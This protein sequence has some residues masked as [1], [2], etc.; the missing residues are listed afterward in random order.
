MKNSLAM[1][2]PSDTYYCNL[3]IEENRPV[4]HVHP[5]EDIEKMEFSFHE[6]LAQLLQYLDSN[7]LLPLVENVDAIDVNSKEFQERMISLQNHWIKQKYILRTCF[8]GYAFHRFE[9]FD[10]DRQSLDYLQNIGI[11]RL[12]KTINTVNPVVSQHKLMDIIGEIESKLNDLYHSRRLTQEQY[13]QMRIHRSKVELNHLLFI[14]DKV[15]LIVHIE[16]SS[17]SF[18]FFL[19]IST[20]R[21]LYFH[22]HK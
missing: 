21:S 11:Y 19:V 7:E 13:D 3:N 18:L 17:N 16:I 2:E 5:V 15:S 4:Q 22:S 14:Y 1:I 9:T 10:F 8:K 20:L 12:I 6:C